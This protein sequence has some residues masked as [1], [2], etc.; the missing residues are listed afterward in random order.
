[1]GALRKRYQKKWPLWAG[2]PTG[3]LR[4]KGRNGFTKKIGDQGGGQTK[5]RRR[6]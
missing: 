4:G 5:N 6:R 1:M 2:Q 3:N